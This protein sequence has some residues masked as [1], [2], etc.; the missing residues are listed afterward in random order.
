M[1]CSQGTPTDSD[2]AQNEILIQK[3]KNPWKGGRIQID[4]LHIK[5]I[6]YFPKGGVIHLNLTAL[7]NVSSLPTLPRY[8][9]T[10]SITNLKA[11]TTLPDLPD[12]LHSLT[13][14]DT[15]IERLPTLPE[16]LQ[17]L[18]VIGTNLTE[19]NDLPNHIQF[20]TCAQNRHLKTLGPLSSKLLALN[21]SDSPLEELPPLPDSLIQLNCELTQ[22]KT[23]P[24]LPP[25][26]K[27][28]KASASMLEVLPPL[29][30]ELV[31]LEVHETP[32]KELPR[33]PFYLHTLYCQHTRLTRFPYLLP[34]RLYMLYCD[35]EFFADLYEIPIHLEHLKVYDYKNSSMPLTSSYHELTE[36]VEA[37]NLK[38]AKQRFT[39]RCLTIK[40]ELIAEVWKPSRVEKLLENGGWTTLDSM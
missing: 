38:R 32:L 24:A 21:C 14:V 36:F 35:T 30:P 7:R 10:L 27:G 17:R 31:V 37:V 3:L 6:P 15:P 28:I 8:L 22:I 23:L 12:T 1:S 13:I 4:Y 11:L 29:P 40:E 39:N 2:T 20:L 5:S 19:L 18:T 26:L 33:L 25:N 9:Q 34:E 16:W